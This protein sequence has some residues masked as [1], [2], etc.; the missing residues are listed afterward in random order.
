MHFTAAQPVLRPL[1]H[2]G[3]RQY[4]GGHRAGTL[5][6]ISDSQRTPHHTHGHGEDPEG[7]TRAI[8][9]AKTKP[10]FIGVMFRARG[11]QHGNARTDCAITAALA[12]KS[13]RLAW[14]GKQRITARRIWRTNPLRT[15]RR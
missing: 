12:R 9:N 15:R 10:H 4:F 7:G 2:G 11:G 14:R 6:G 3:L 8:A 13:R 1:M 5:S